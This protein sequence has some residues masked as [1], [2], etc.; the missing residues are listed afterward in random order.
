MLLFFK[1]PHSER[2]KNIPLS[3]IAKLCFLIFVLCFIIDFLSV[4]IVVKYFYFS[5]GFNFKYFEGQF[6]NLNTLIFI[7]LL[8][9]GYELLF[10]APILLFTNYKKVFPYIFYGLAIAYGSTYIFYYKLT[11]NIFFV[12]P[13]LVIPKIILGLFLGLLRVRFGLIYAVIFHVFYATIILLSFNII[14]KV[15]F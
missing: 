5:G 4:F 2:A 3:Y 12:T 14:T 13:F 15:L 7:C 10:R 8:P 11:N 6:P 9:I 1:T